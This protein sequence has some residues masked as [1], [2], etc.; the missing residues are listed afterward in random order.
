MPLFRLAVAAGEQPQLS[1]RDGVSPGVY[2]PAVVRPL[3]GPIDRIEPEFVDPQI[4]G[5][6]DDDA[7]RDVSL[8]ALGRNHHLERH[9]DDQVPDVEATVVRMKVLA[10]VDE[11]AEQ[12]SRWFTEAAAWVRT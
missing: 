6:G 3:L 2:Q 12:D 10:G 9:A 11:T 8:V 4:V 7:L 5:P 1:C